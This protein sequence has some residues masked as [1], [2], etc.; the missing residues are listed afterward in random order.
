MSKEQPTIGAD[1]EVDLSSST[2]VL[3]K[4]ARDHPAIDF[5]IVSSEGSVDSKRLYLIQVSSS[6]YQHRPKERRLGA[7]N[8]NFSCLQNQTPYNYFRTMFQ[9]RSAE[10]FYIYSTTC[11]IPFDSSFSTVQR[12]KDSVYFHQ[13]HF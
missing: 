5:V 9:M 13:L 7:V 12:E 2:S 6:Q 11:F 10:V 3:I 1:V 8:D 4:L